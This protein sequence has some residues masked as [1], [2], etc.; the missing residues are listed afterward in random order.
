MQL[1]CGTMFR[2]NYE[3]IGTCVSDI[4][5]SQGLGQWEVFS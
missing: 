5:V 1:V 2:G 3:G 4:E